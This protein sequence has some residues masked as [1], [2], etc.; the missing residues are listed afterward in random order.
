MLFLLKH[1]IYRFDDSNFRMRFAIN[2]DFML[3][4]FGPCN[5]KVALLGEAVVPTAVPGCEPVSV[6][7]PGPSKRGASQRLHIN[8]SVGIR[9]GSEVCLRLNVE[10]C[11]GENCLLKS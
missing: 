4:L 7:L 11:C 1:H 5:V 8:V 3:Q 6:F 2:N 10:T 9:V